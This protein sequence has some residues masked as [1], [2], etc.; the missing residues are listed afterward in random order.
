M[1]ACPLSAPQPQPL[2]VNARTFLLPDFSLQN[3]RKTEIPEEASV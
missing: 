2:A 3:D 1:G